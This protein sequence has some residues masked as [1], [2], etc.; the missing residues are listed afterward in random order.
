MVRECTIFPNQQF[1]AVRVLFGSK[2]RLSRLNKLKHLKTFN[3]F[4]LQ[5]LFETG[6]GGAIFHL[7][8]SSSWTF[9]LWFRGSTQEQQF[10]RRRGFSYSW[11]VAV[12]MEFRWLWYLL[13]SWLLFQRLTLRQNAVFI[14]LYITH[15]YIRTYTILCVNYHYLNLAER[16]VLLVAQVARMMNDGIHLC[17]LIAVRS[18]P[19]KVTR[20]AF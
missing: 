18:D 4:R 15:V 8:L 13:L 11:R 17:E 20:K 19:W 10:L 5:H 3:N 14:Y 1:W 2:T 6:S 16:E 12:T 9:K 7:L